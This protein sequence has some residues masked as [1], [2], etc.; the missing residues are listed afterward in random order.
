MVIVVADDEAAAG[1]PCQ[2]PLDRLSAEQDLEGAAWQT[3]GE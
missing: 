3:T 1:D 2:S